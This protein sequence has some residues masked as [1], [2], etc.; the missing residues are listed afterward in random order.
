MIIK[1]LKSGSSDWIMFDRIRKVHKIEEEYDFDPRVHP[2]DKSGYANGADYRLFDTWQKLDNESDG[3]KVGLI[4]FICTLDSG[5][6]YSISF[7]T[8]AYICNDDGKTI[9]KVVANN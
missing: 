1:L 5:E 2:V 3:C 8:I 6:E 4:T 9:E 7:D